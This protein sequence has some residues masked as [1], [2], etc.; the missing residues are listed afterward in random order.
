M[1][2][3]SGGRNKG[4]WSF[5]VKIC[6]KARSAKVTHPFNIYMVDVKYKYLS[7]Q[8]KSSKRTSNFRR[9]RSFSGPLIYCRMYAHSSSTWPQL[10]Q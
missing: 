1:K 7:C 8:G 3:R 9:T 4:G 2:G 5:R 6:P 10:F